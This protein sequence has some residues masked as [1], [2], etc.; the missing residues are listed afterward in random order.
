MSKLKIFIY[1]YFPPIA[2]MVLIYYL[3]SIPNLKID[4]TDAEFFRRKFVHLF[5][6]GLL[7][8]LIYRALV[9]GKWLTEFRK[10]SSKILLSLFLTTFYGATD[11]IHQM[12][13]Q[14]R[15]GKI[16][17]LIFDFLGGVSGIAVLNFIQINIKRKESKEKDKI[18][19]KPVWPLMLGVVILL[20][21]T[22]LLVL[23]Y[24]SYCPNFNLLV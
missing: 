23:Y 2:F 22:I 6:Y 9:K 10:N 14:T 15:T 20:I 13:V 12:Y 1:Y 3:S 21:L 19:K 8:L 11:E 18:F 16:T 4:D 7:W 24:D 5:E 17:D